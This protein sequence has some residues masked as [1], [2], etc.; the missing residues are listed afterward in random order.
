M[1][2]PPRISVLI[3]FFTSP[4]R[5]G[6]LPRLRLV[7]TGYAAQR[8]TAPGDVEVIVVDDGSE[9]PL[10][11]VLA[12]WDVGAVRLVTTRHRGMC[13]AYNEGLA[14]ARA[15]VVLLGS[16]DIVPGPFLLARH[17]DAHR[18]PA[19]RYVSGRELF[20]LHCAL[21]DDPEDGLPDLGGLAE[22]AAAAG[23]HWFAPAVA[24]LGL[25]DKPVT[26]RMVTEEWNALEMLATVPAGYADIYAAL[27][28]GSWRELAAPWLVTRVGNHSVRRDVL[29]ALGG[30]DEALDDHGGWYADLDL[31]I[32]M[33][34]RGVGF[35]YEP[36][37]TSVNLFHTKSA[38]VAVGEYTG[39]A[40]LLGRYPEPA[41]ALVPLFFRD[42]MDLDTYDALLEHVGPYWSLQRAGSV[43]LG[44]TP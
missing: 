13:H 10:A 39:L 2:V 9:P 44:A 27:R 43:P 19:P 11:P 30:F 5:R 42:R 41:V 16:D 38:D 32:R 25:A 14:A 28:S 34:R 8:G 22:R 20:L 7:L 17:L 21:F 26:R 40:Y 12:D 29:V 36:E 37:A 18:G 33:A 1:T 6:A 15:P 23:D 24:H 4:D 3:P 35:G 31:G